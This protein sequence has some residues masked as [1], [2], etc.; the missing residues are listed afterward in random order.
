MALPGF[1]A[2]HGLYVSTRRYHTAAYYG[3]GGEVLPASCTAPSCVTL[4]KS[5]D[6]AFC[7]LAGALQ[8]ARIAD[9]DCREC[10]EDC[11]LGSGEDCGTQCGDDCSECVRQYLCQGSC[12]G[13]KC[14]RAGQTCINGMCLSVVCNA[15]YVNCGGRCVDPQTD[16]NN[17][18]ACGKTCATRQTCCNGSCINP[19][20]DPNNCGGC[21]KACPAGQTCCNGS[22]LAPPGPDAP[23]GAGNYMLFSNCQP[24]EGLKV[25][26]QVGSED[27]VSPNGFSLQLNAWPTALQPASQPC[28]PASCQC[29]APSGVCWMQ[30]L[31]NIEGNQA[32]AFLQYWD[33]SGVN[34]QGNPVIATLPTPNTLPAGWGLEISLSND[35]S[36]NVN[37]I[38]LSVIN[39]QGQPVGSLPMPIPTLND[40]TPILAPIRAFWV[41][42]VGVPTCNTAT[43]SSGNGCLTYQVSNGQLCVQDGNNCPNVAELWGVCENS[44]TSYGAM[45]ATCGSSL[46]Q[47]LTVRAPQRPP[48]CS[49]GA[50]A[51]CAQG[52]TCLVP[53]GPPDCQCEKCACP[54]GTGPNYCEG[55]GYCCNPGVCHCMACSRKPCHQF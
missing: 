5:A 47:S 41:D 33:N 24:I 44:N 29:P 25:S 43:F 26:L 39:A 32:I 1:A 51:G 34:E 49:N 42:V 10:T 54:A 11:F 27:L 35:S 15:P 3:Q 20:T 22:C 17:C 45:N 23:G 53:G 8:C 30:Y 6:Y 55:G 19:T 7:D 28:G 36:G 37:G 12:C 48:T 14:C 16:S 21:G 50:T 2:E 52:M 18:G 46:T 38:T 13:T 31:I 40:S 4:L 9:L